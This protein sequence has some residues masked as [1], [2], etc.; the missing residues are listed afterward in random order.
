MDVR[1]LSG[2]VAVVTGAA[3][4]IGR[5]TALALARR[6]ADL[7]VCDVDETGLKEVAAEIHRLGRRVVSER[8]DVASA[9]A[10]SGFADRCFSQLERVDVLV[11]NAGIGVGGSF[12]DVPLEEWDAIIGINLK[13]VVH[14]CSFFLP[15]MIAA[16]RGGHV[17]NIA[18][19]AG[20]VA[21]PG[22]SA[23][24]MTKFG[25]I[26]FSESL[27]SDLADDGIGVSAI[28]PGII[29]TPIVRSSRLY[30]PGAT[31]E[32]RQRG[33]EAFERRNYGPERVARG[34]LK[35]IQKNRAVA[36]IS[37]EAWVGYWLKRLAPG[38]LRAL[39]NLAA[40]RSRAAIEQPAHAAADGDRGPG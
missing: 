35:A 8:V 4:G 36:P 14:G 30:G 39:V 22:M 19:M 9:A 2:K 18:S 34:I 25:V 11:N 33:I 1:D 21:T 32:N 13:G 28:C 16:G 5:E 38:L 27:R 6:G 26:G 29:N 20:Y 31:L 37:P 40:R 3:S 12:I 17:V 23:Y 24:S 15:R 7:A 10:M